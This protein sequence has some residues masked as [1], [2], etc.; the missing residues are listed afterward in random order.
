VVDANEPGSAVEHTLAPDEAEYVPL[1]QG[2]ITLYAPANEPGEARK[3]DEAP[4]RLDEPGLQRVYPRAP[5][6]AGMPL[7]AAVDA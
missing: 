3:Q 1:G 7:S 5:E 4:A 2:W 6:L